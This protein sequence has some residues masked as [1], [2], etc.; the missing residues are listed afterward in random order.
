MIPLSQN[1]RKKALEILQLDQETFARFSAPYNELA[2]AINILFTNQEI[3]TRYTSEKLNE[4]VDILYQNKAIA[5]QKLEGTFNILL[6]KDPN[7]VAAIFPQNKNNLEDSLSRGIRNHVAIRMAGYSPIIKEGEFHQGLKIITGAYNGET[8]E[9]QKKLS[10]L[11]EIFNS[12]HLKTSVTLIGT[13]EPYSHKEL[14]NT[15]QP[16]SWQEIALIK[17][18][19]EYNLIPLRNSDMPIETYFPE[20]KVPFTFVT[21]KGSF[22]AQ[23][24]S[25]RNGQDKKIKG[26]YIC[27]LGDGGLGKWYGKEQMTPQDVLEISVIDPKKVYALRK[28]K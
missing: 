24:T 6:E 23:I 12:V 14:E 18:A 13:N 15:L 10:M 17:S 1:L 8:M 4:L 5:N 27:S 25:K 19:I 3:R 21:T 16:W 11:P 26:S 2:N 20:F 28:K 9:L 7:Q 22:N